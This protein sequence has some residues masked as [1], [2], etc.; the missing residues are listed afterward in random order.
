M[1]F[2]VLWFLVSIKEGIGSDSVPWAMF[3]VA[4]AGVCEW[5]VN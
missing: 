2:G 5:P 1:P 4:G 3:M